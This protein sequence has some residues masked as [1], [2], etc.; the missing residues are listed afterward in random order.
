MVNWRRSTGLSTTAIA[1]NLRPG[2]LSRG[3]PAKHASGAER[4]GRGFRGAG[5]YSPQTMS[6]YPILLEM[7]KLLGNMGGWLDKAES[8][9]SAKG[10]DPNTLLQARLAPDMFPL[11]SQFQS[12]CD[13][14]KF[15]AAFSTGRC[16]VAR[17]SRATSSKYCP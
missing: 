13:N 12:A 8:H 16:S 2:A 9:A 15:A 7:K 10:Y 17:P 11:V 4:R 1:R 6:L 3:T 5:G 14:A